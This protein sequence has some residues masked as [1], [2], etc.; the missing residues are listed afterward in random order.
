MSFLLRPV[1]TFRRSSSASTRGVEL[2]AS[3]TPYPLAPHLE[4]CVLDIG[5]GRDASIVPL[6]EGERFLRF[7][8]AELTGFD[9]GE[10][11]RS[12]TPTQNRYRS[13]ALDS[14]PLP[15]TAKQPLGVVT[16][17]ARVPGARRKSV[18]APSK[19][20]GAENGNGNPNQ[21]NEAPKKQSPLRRM[22][23]YLN[24][25]RTS[26]TKSPGSKKHAHASSSS[27]RV[28]SPT[29][30]KAKP[31]ISSESGSPGASP[32]KLES[33]LAHPA[34]E[35][36]DWAARIRS[37]FY[38]KTWDAD[39]DDDDDEDDLP[40]SIREFFTRDSVG[41]DESVD[42]GTSTSNAD[43]HED[44]YGRPLGVRSTC[45]SPSSPTSP[46]SS[47][48]SSADSESLATPTHGHPH[49][50]SSVHSSSEL[51]YLGGSSNSHSGASGLSASSS[52]ASG[53]FNDL[54]ASVG[55][56]YPGR[57]WPEIVQFSGPSEDGHGHGHGGRGDGGRA[58]GGSINGG[59]GLQQ[60]SDVFCLDE[61]AT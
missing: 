17:F 53:A 52:G 33:C 50:L 21:E 11:R 27:F 15:T 49:A 18:P 14:K 4:G 47:P 24:L 26:P 48:D 19:T 22:P 23:R 58:C 35:S 43:A 3:V 36:V 42:G 51:P 30:A 46:S 39:G 32:S 12:A 61:Y 38:N 20:R 2:H 16:N 57:H 29:K 28:E 54:L 25:A 34:D 31:D 40:E 56:K 41:S 5:V 8:G 45:S 60:W 10:T 44:D 7:G 1:F 59:K 55:R 37:V 9:A 6:S 13:R